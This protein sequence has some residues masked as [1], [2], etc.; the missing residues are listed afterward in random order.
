MLTL[1]DPS[2]P[3]TAHQMAPDSSDGPFRRPDAEG[4][5]GPYD[6]LPAPPDS[7]KPSATIPQGR[8]PR[9]A[10]RHGEAFRSPSSPEEDPPKTNSVEKG[11]DPNYKI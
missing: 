7:E 3:P 1:A 2:A 10:G 9:K 4:F 6:Y 8:L 11:Y 5:G